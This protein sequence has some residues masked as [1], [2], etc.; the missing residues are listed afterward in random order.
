M[1]VT[2]HQTPE[3]FT[4]SDNPIVW[5]FSSNQTAQDNFYYLVKVYVN[6]NLVGN[7]VYFPE[8]GI[9]SRFDG[10][11]YA[12]NNCN[13]PQI[14]DDLL[15]DAANYCEIRIT[16]VER[17]GSP[18]ADGAST[19]GTNI[20]AWKARMD[21]EDFVAWDPTDYIYGA[22]GNFLTNNPS[23]PKVRTEGEDFRLLFIND[24]TS[25]TAFKVE[26][27]DS[28][29][30]SIVSDTVNFTATSFQLLV[31][32][33]SPA[34]IVASALSIS[35]AS[36][37]AASYYKISANAGAGMIEYQIDIDTDCVFSTYKRLHFLAQ[38]GNIESY[39]F[40]LLARKS[41][42]IKSYG[43]QKTFGNYQG[44]Q[45]VFSD[46][47]G[48]MVDH[49]K[50]ITRKMVITSDFLTEAVQNYLAVNL[51]GSPLVYLQDP[52]ISGS[53]LKRR[54]IT[55]PTFKESIQENDQIFLLVAEI[56][57]T[58]ITSMTV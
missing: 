42:N 54:R 40:A 44:N 52:L 5:V 31:A 34:A 27:F 14:S 53:P 28:S 55:N 19:V 16:I 29:G 50:H 9:Y 43:Y 45:Y 48:Q 30:S 47:D 24:E 10:S 8:S 33:V 36:F 39:S 32:N 26:L 12:S 58:P 3:D 4:P 13:T 51:L 7:E 25:I 56:E 22:P 41:G 1:A 49:A 37:N 20:V 38:W 17:Y 57:L 2:I 23:T 6:D 46:S 35:Q 15:A 11:S 21:D 18:V